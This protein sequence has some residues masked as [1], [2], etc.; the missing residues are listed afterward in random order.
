MLQH[1]RTLQER[2]QGRT[3]K[4]EH[5]QRKAFSEFIDKNRKP[6]AKGLSI[7][8]GDGIWDHLAFKNGL[9][10]I[11][12]TDIVPNPV[13]SNDQKTLRQQGLWNFSQVAKDE[14]LPWPDNHF[15]IS[16]SQDVI[17]HTVKPNLFISEQLRILKPGG[18]I[19]VGTP[20]IF[21]PTNIIR[22]FF[23]NLN[24]PMKIGSNIEIGDYIHE[25]EFHE[26]Q[27]FLGLQEAGFE[28]ISIKHIFFGLHS[29]DISFSDHP[30]FNVGK[31][32]SHFLFATASKPVVLTP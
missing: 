8:C 30:D 17:E 11:E 22:A 23:G 29:I 9:S 10:I 27:L 19:A 26:R 15:D 21:R 12:A 31:T 5:L 2:L 24:F 14:N 28:H 16:F 4:V 13:S 6:N 1:L 7:S 18:H 20:N 32:F 25:Q 3:S